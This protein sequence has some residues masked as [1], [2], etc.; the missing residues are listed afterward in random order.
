MFQII[1]MDG[2]HNFTMAAV[3]GNIALYRNE[4][5]PKDIHYAHFKKINY[6]TIV[7]GIG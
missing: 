1:L 2:D 7:Q 4:A 3:H 5:L 6:S